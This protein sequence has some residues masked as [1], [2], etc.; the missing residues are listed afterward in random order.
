MSIDYFKNLLLNLYL[1]RYNRSVFGTIF[2]L[3]FTMY[4][5]STFMC[6]FDGF[7]TKDTCNGMSK[8]FWCENFC[9]LND[10][11][12][13]LDQGFN[14]YTVIIGILSALIYCIKA[15]KSEADNV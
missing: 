10:T 8:R 11:C 7:S 3:F 9:E 14:I 12:R 6:N 4:V 15:L 13:W 5:Y 1:N 2:I